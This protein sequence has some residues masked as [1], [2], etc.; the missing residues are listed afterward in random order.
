MPREDL[1]ACTARR[2]A[3]TGSRA[4]AAPAPR[5]RRRI[6]FLDE[7]DAALERFLLDRGDGAWACAPGG[8]A[9]AEPLESQLVKAILEGAA[10]GKRGLHGLPGYSHAAAGGRSADAARQRCARA[11]TK[12]EQAGLR[13]RAPLTAPPASARTPA[14]TRALSS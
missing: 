3:L 10:G 14:A 8:G 6:E 11:G 1:S 12:V 9:H 2:G 7:L 13:A 5:R 4:R